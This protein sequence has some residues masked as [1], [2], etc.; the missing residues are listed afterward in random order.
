MCYEGGENKKMMTSPCGH[1]ACKE[2]WNKWLEQKAECP[3]CRAKVRAKRLITL[4]I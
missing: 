2:C 1:I 3:Q 4:H